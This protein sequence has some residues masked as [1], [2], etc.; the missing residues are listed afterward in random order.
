MFKKTVFLLTF[1]LLG[2]SQTLIKQTEKNTDTNNYV[3]PPKIQVLNL[4][5]FHFGQSSDAHTVEF[6]EQDAANQQEVRA[7][8]QLIARFKPTIICLEFLPEQTEQINQA[9]QAF[10]ADPSELDTR[11]GE[12]SMLGFDVARLSGISKL[13]GIDYHLGYNYS[14]GDFIEQSDELE[15]AIDRSTYL[16]LTHQPL[17]HYPQLAKRYAQFDSLSLQQKLILTNEPLML[18][19][20]LNTNA[21]KLFYVGIGEGFE[22]AEQAAQFYLR[23]MKIYSNLNRIPLRNNDRVLI[24]MGSAH[25]AML[26]EFI[27]RSPK[28]QMVDTH[29]YLKP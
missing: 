14:L 28:F 3:G 24:L 20:S 19:Y 23:N 2:C 4:G 21:D 11:Y 16:Q 5:S 29:H 18:D 15:N 7:I 27:Q 26:R 9:Y 10:L 8:A 17:K 22:G 25:T 12:L 1:M 13:Y 6:D